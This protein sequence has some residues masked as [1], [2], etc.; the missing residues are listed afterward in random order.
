M[1]ELTLR[2]SLLFWGRMDEVE[3]FEDYS[4]LIPRDC[5]RKEERKEQISVMTSVIELLTW[6]V[7]S[8]FF[9]ADWGHSLE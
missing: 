8:D 9:V 3:E 1:K 5:C 4:G 7:V 2:V 6:V